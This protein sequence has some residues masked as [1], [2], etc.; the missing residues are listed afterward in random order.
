MVFVYAA[1]IVTVALFILLG[2]KK[3]GE[4]IY[5]FKIRGR[6]L[7]CVFGLLIMGFGCYA[8]VPANSVGIL[9]SPFSGVSDNT[10]PE[11]IHIKSPFDTIYMLSTEVQTQSIADVSGQTK[12]AQYLTMVVDIKYR[13]DPQHAFEVFKQFRTLENM[14]RSLIAPTV[15][16]SI[17]SVTTQYN[18]IAVLGESRN[19]V[20]KGV[21][22]ELSARLA[23]NGV[24]FYSM[25]FTDTD[26]G[27]AIENAIQAEA[28]AKKAVETAEQERL[29]AEIEAQKRVVEAQADQDKA[30]IDA[31]TKVIGAQAEAEANRLLAQSIT[32]QLIRLKEAE[33]RMKHGWITVQGG[34]AIVDTR[35]G[36]DTAASYYPPSSNSGE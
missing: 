19:E 26:A 24:S 12:D 2:M 22:E 1:A 5:K 4:N 7:L 15:Q 6:Q 9:Y 28:V 8:V 31:E 34:T 32:E 21:E 11:G 30:R 16:R 14:N 29:K 33:A 18:V 10:L 20:Y 3:E 35:A 36:T 13:V 23:D 17:E 25:T 27:S